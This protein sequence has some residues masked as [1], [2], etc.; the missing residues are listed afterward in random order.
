MRAV[1][2]KSVKIN[3]IRVI[4]PYVSVHQW[5]DMFSTVVCQLRSGV[6]VTSESRL[7]DKSSAYWIKV[8]CGYIQSHDGS[9]SR[10]YA[11]SN[12]IEANAAWFLEESKRQRMASAVASMLIKSYP[13]AKAKR[14][15]RTLLKHAYEFYPNPHR[16]INDVLTGTSEAFSSAAQADESA[17]QLQAATEVVAK[18]DS[19]RSKHRKTD[20]TVTPLVIH[21]S[22]AIED[23]MISLKGEASSFPDSDFVFTFTLIRYRPAVTAEG[24]RVRVREDRLQR[25][26]Q[27]AAGRAAHH[28]EHL[29]ADEHAAHALDHERIERAG[30]RVGAHEQR[31]V[32][33]GRGQR[34]PGAVHA[35]PA[36]R[37]GAHQRA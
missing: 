18:P 17:D 36:Q 27:P 8:S 20:P 14:F 32:H 34:R 1:I 5:P 37:T 31:P 28:R 13:L 23:I 7:S 9:G 22:L 35:L 12:I 10:N 33:H 11:P 6:F 2:P 16:S 19:R 3:I 29:Q 26:V 24:G 30:D 21:S 4:A 15:A 25:A